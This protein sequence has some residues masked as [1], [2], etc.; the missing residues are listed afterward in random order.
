MG[1]DLVHALSELKET[2]A[3][4]IVRKRLDGGE[5]P[6]LILDEAR[7]AMGIVGKRFEEGTYF[8]PDLIYSGEILQAISEMVRPKIS[9]EA[10]GKKAGKVVLGTVKGDIHDIGKNIVAFMLDLNGFE[11]YDIGIDVPPEKF[12]EKIRETNAPVVALSGFLTLA[13]D[14]MKA[15]VEAIEKAGLRDK[16]KIIIGGGNMNEDIRKYAGADA[17][18]VDAMA[19]VSFA[20]KVVPSR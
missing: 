20:E 5:N 7:K 19:A 15:T 6:L 8:I 2:E 9:K 17:Y 11:V 4:E 18:G 16:V 3:L 1:A 13:F 10:A 12:V 14:A